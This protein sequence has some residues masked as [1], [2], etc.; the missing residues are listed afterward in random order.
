MRRY[1]KHISIWDNPETQ[2]LGSSAEEFLRKLPGPTVI[3]VRGKRTQET[4]AVCT[5]LHGNEPSGTLA[6]YHWLKRKQQP[7]CNVALFIASVETAL[8][9]PGF[10]Y[11]QLPGNR[12]LN[13]CFIPPFDDREGEI[14]QE[15]MAYLE[16]IQPTSVLD[17]H[18]TSGDGPAFAVSIIHDD[19][20]LRLAS[21]FTHR[22]IHTPLRMGALME[23][24]QHSMPIVTIECGGAREQESHELALNGLTRYLNAEQIDTIHSE[25]TFELFHNPVRVVMQKESSIDYQEYNN[26]QVDITL[27]PGIERFNFG[28]VQPE[29]QLGWLSSGDLNHL[30]AINSYQENVIDHILKVVDR[31][32]YP[33]RAI[34][35]FMATTNPTIAKSDCLFYVVDADGREI[36]RGPVSEHDND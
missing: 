18:N 22:I 21:F 14:A 25:E 34:K 4:R 24:S 2:T 31:K 1:R 9:V 11:R 12:D 8:T 7:A 13:R 35:L 23:L 28:I 6:A 36:V 29:T 20:H 10:H 19:V 27:S 32:I 5:L 26:H 3:F 15:F 17:I 16:E 30:Q 33:A